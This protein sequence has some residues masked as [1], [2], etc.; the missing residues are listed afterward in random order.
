MVKLVSSSYYFLRK[1][2]RG[3][4]D[5]SCHKI[6]NLDPS[7]SPAQDKMVVVHGHTHHIV[8]GKTADKFFCLDG[9][10]ATYSIG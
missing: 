2:C 7:V 10:D 4:D 3:F 6:N 1:G 5:G 8:S 9:P